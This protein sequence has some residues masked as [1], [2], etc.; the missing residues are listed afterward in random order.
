MKLVKEFEKFITRGNVVD[1]AI[2]VA[3]GGAF[4]KVVTSLV[5]DII[6]P[7]IGWLLQGINFGNFKW[8]LQVGTDG[9]PEIAIGYG[10]LIQAGFEFFVIALVVFLFVKILNRL[11]PK[12]EKPPQMPTGE[13]KL[14]TEIRDL[15]K[16][17][18]K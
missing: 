5:G 14:L 2:A 12:E 11:R 7:P 15:L 1:L 17:Q 4:G 6:L 8:V 9:T 3:I 18:S 16:K 13:E 10:K